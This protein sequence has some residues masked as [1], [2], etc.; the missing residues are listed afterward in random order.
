MK[1][2]SW[3]QL[4]LLLLVAF[5]LR[6]AAGWAWQSRLAGPFGMGDS[7][8]YWSL[9]KAIAHGEPYQYGSADARVFRTPGYPVL[10][11]PIVGL[12]GDGRT[13]VMLARAEAALLGTLAVLGV[14]W[15]ARLLFDDRAAMLAAGLATFYPGG[16]VLSALILSEAP[17]C[18]LMLLQLG[19]WILAWRAPSSGRRAGLG[20]SAGLA[21]GAATLMRPSWLLFTP[22]AAAVGMFVREKNS[23]EL[24][25][26]SRGLTAPGTVSSRIAIA[27]W[28]MFGLVTAMLPWWIRNAY[29]TGHFVPTTL[30]VG[31]SLYDGLS[32]QATGASDL[33]A[34]VP[35]FTAEE[36]ASQPAAEDA[37][38]PQEPFEMRL[39]HRMR[40][41]ALRWAWENPGRALRLAGVKFLRMWNVW[42]NEP[43]LRSWPV[44]LAVFFTY[45]PLAIFAIIGAWR[46][47]DRGWPYVLCWLP[48][49]YLTLLH[50]VFV[51][52]IRYREPAMLALLA[53]AAGGLV[54]CVKR[55]NIE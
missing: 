16:I 9:A 2:L 53:L 24:T 30:Q 38:K 23:R 47:L 6:L 8:S 50:V 20:F 28:M 1:S 10:L 52:S 15:L 51:S 14:W 27:S 37:G 11:A 41:A 35:R 17:F 48:A 31:A 18:P 55:T 54:G 22:L 36:R 25:A 49:V 40:D 39:D 45:T 7:E 43:R 3:R 26:N 33:E 34:F 19:L 32:P 4:G 42:P 44:G 5:L 21:A 46:T 13:A 12:A 29:V